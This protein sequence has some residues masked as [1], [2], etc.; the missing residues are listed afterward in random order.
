MTAGSVAVVG[1]GTMGGRIAAAFAATGRPTAGADPYE[2]ARVAAAGHGVAV[3]DSPGEAVAG[4]DLVVLSLPAP[5]QVLEVAG[6]L[7]GRVARGALVADTSTIDPG[8]AREAASRL[9]AAGARYV[10]A[11]VLGRPAG[12]GAWTLVTGGAEAD[13]AELAAATVGV[14]AKAVRRA[15]DVGAGSTVK[16]LNNLMFGAI[17]AVTAEVVDLAERA[18]IPAAMFAD[19]VADSGA[20]TVSPL[21]RDIAP[22]MAA[23]DYEPAFTL[24]LLQKDVRLGAALAAALGAPAEVTTAVEA[25]TTAAVESGRAADDTAALVEL[26]RARR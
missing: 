24:A 1:L 16:V 20:A 13:V 3:T 9:T 4:A 22:R 12:V 6:A 11:P 8:T 25:L 7:A 15:G 10:D 14:I 21:F 19:V 17:N 26:L 18:G 23:G 2:A 5:R